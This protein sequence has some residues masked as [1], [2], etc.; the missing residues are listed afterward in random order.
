[1]ALA[2]LVEDREGI[3]GAVRSLI[4]NNAVEGLCFEQWQIKLLFVGILTRSC[5][6][7]FIS[8]RHEVEPLVSER[9]KKD[10]EKMGKNR[11]NMCLMAVNPNNAHL[12][13]AFVST[14]TNK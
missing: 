10:C 14:Q 8:T 3:G 1:M 9:F 4:W 2:S 12:N 11:K 7:H 6:V 13:T 5:S